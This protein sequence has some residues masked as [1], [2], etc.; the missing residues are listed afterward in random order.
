[1]HRNVICSIL[2]M[3]A[4]SVIPF[5][6]ARADGTCTNYGWH[7]T[8]VQHN[9]LNVHEH[10]DAPPQWVLDSEMPP[11]AQCRE[12]HQGYKGVYSVSAN[13]V[14]SYAIYHI[15]STTTAQGLA[16]H[17]YQLWTREPSGAISTWGKL[18]S[19]NTSTLNFGTSTVCQDPNIKGAPRPTKT[20]FNQTHGWY[21]LRWPDV[22]SFLE[23]QWNITGANEPHCVPTPVTD[24]T[25]RNALWTLDRAEL[26]NVD[27]RVLSPTLQMYCI[28]SG[29][30]FALAFNRAQ[31]DYGIAAVPN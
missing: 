13:N 16:N 17:D 30:G 9:G 27:T 6:S 25:S 5:G 19:S 29:K 8:T 2:L 1:M 20:E 14:E 18:G 24:G 10:G 12:L 22:G 31:F 28:P 7:D 11:F 15:I 26:N 21:T 4:F 23:V 3:L